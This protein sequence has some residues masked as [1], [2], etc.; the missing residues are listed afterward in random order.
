M[1]AKKHSSKLLKSKKN[2]PSKQIP[3]LRLEKSFI[4]MRSLKKSP[5]IKDFYKF[6]LDY[7]LRKE[8]AEIFEQTLIHRRKKNKK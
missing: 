1:D 7:N 6:V 5:E 4:S 3:K 2:H 8:S